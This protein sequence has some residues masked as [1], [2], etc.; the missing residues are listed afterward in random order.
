VVAWTKSNNNRWASEWLTWPG[1]S[2]LWAQIVRS[3]MRHKEHEA[4]DLRA[5]VVDGR[6]RVAVDAIDRDDR[7]VNGLDTTLE[8]IDPR[9]SKVKRSLPMDQ[10]AAGRYEA[11]L[12]I[13]R[14]GTFVLKAVHRREGRTVAESLGAVSLP[15]PAEYLRSTPDPEPLRQIGV[16]TGGAAS[17]EPA[18]VIKTAGENIR[19]HRDLWPM[20][21][22][23]VACAFMLDLYL[24]RLRLFGY[25][26]MKF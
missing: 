25:R 12:P 3:T 18:D 7:F 13:D 2:K 17:P 6:A 8:V 14:Y 10:T 23:A 5:E 11:D 24:R 9:D 1:Y 26:P 19:Y 20:V 21:L 4:Y 15:Y 22:L 16:V